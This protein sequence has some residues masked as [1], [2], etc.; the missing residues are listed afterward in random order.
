MKFLNNFIRILIFILW[1]FVVFYIS[2]FFGFSYDP[3]DTAFWR[4]LVQVIMVVVIFGGGYFI[5][6]IT[7][8]KPKKPSQES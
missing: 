5:R 1:A 7:L 6:K 8:F 4:K 2:K 3:E